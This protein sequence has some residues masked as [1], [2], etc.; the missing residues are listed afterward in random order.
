MQTKTLH[1]GWIIVAVSFCVLLVGAAVRAAPGVMMIPLELE[2]GWDRTVVSLALSISLLLYGLLG[3]FAAAMM[4]RF[5]IKQVIL[6]A[7]IILLVSSIS[8]MWMNAA[9]QVYLLWGVLIGIGSSSTSA[10][11][12]VT[13]NEWFV[14][15]Q[16]FVVGILTASG[17]TGQILFLPLLAHFITV[18]GWR[19]A[20]WILV[21]AVGIVIMLVF[22]LLKNSPK[23]CELLPYGASEPIFEHGRNKKN[24][25]IEAF[26]GLKLTVKSTDFW[27]LA[28]SFF[29]CGLSTSGLIGTHFIPLCVEH[30]ISEITAASML[31]TI[32]I[33]DLIGTIFSGWLS[34]RFS[35]RWLLFWYYGLRGL[36]L[37]LLPLL[38]AS[39]HTALWVFII[40]YGLDWVATVPPTVK[41]TTVT[42]GKEKAGIIF[43]WIFMFHQLGASVAAYGGGWMRAVSNSYYY[44]FLLA[45]A[46]CLLATGI[47]LGIGKKSVKQAI[48]ES[49]K[50]Y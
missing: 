23:D 50:Q 8:T 39:S 46:F 14:K 11:S 22:F 28:G 35:N 9:W 21:F 38:L 7:L 33:F 5:G 25:I 3:P 40:F 36:F 13:A 18:S 6:S 44:T 43:G 26:E 4:N 48:T 19:N 42:F 30:G 10:L 47:V 15:K 17:A 16:G 41:L 1:Y 34:D 37:L 31:A 29:I 27:L 32:G 45:G 12:A 2:F 24:P 20:L 49:V